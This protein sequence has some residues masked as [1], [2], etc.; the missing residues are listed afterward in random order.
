MVAIRQR[1]FKNDTIQKS[2]SPDLSLLTT[3]IISIPLKPALI[4]LHTKLTVFALIAYFKSDTEDLR[5]LE[6]NACVEDE[7]FGSTQLLVS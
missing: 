6:G 7:F 5:C 1:T 4:Y 3:P 2:Y